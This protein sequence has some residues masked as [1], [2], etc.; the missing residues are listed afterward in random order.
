MR[1]GKKVILEAKYDNIEYMQ[2]NNSFVISANNKMGV[3]S[4]DGKT[5][6]EPIYEEMNLIDNKQNYF[7]V[8]KNN[9]YGLID[10]NGNEIIYIENEKIGIDISKYEA[11]GIKNGYILLDRLVPLMQNGKWGFFD[12][13]LKRTSKFRYDSIGCSS[14]NGSNTY[15][16]LILPEYDLIVIQKNGKYAFL[17]EYGNEDIVPFVFDKMYLRISSGEK[18]YYMTTSEGSYNIFK[19]LEKI[20]IKKKNDKDLFDENKNTNSDSSTVG[21]NGDS[22]A[23]DEND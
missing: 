13:K 2:S 6:V 19:S 3:I 15:P 16:L 20:G 12:L 11:N 23:N 8:K 1:G 17:D 22:K 18:K 9:L 7:L 4:A 21:L 5:K 10:E 14:T